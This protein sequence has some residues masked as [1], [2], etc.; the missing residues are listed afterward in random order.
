MAELGGIT[1]STLRA[2]SRGSSEVPQPQATGG[3]GDPWARAVADDW[4]EKR[5]RSYEGVKA[6]M[7]AGDRDELCR[8]A[9]EVRDHFAADFQSTLWDRPDVRKRWVLRARNQESGKEVSDALAW[10][11]AVR[12][13]RIVPTQ[14][15]GH[16][17]ESAV[18]HDFADAI[19][20]DREVGARTKGRP[21]RK[22]WSHLWVSPPVARCS[23]GSSA[24]TRGAITGG[25]AYSTV[26]GIAT[27]ASVQSL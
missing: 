2:Y 20:L 1:A 23:T 26:A 24:T 9:A 6:A 25:L 16:T 5:H 7:P 13:D 11:V 3:G 15:L 22:E 10:T 17:V 14:F 18:I 8:G 27:K 4:V 12:L 21:K 19:D